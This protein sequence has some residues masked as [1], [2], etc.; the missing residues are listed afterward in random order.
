MQAC[1]HGSFLFAIDNGLASYYNGANLSTR[2]HIIER[3]A[4]NDP[5]FDGMCIHLSP[6]RVLFIYSWCRRYIWYILP[7]IIGLSLTLIFESRNLLRR[8]RMTVPR[9]RLAWGR[10]RLR[11]GPSRAVSSPDHGL[12]IST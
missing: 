12:S 6:V 3:D 5:I 11:V 7:P 1:S 9:R 8:M 10:W 4:R 2:R